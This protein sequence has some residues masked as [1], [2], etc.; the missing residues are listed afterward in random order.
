MAYFSAEYKITL[1]FPDR[2]LINISGQD[3]TN[4]VPAEVLEILPNQAFKGKLSDEATAN[5]ILA[6][7][8]PPNIN[9]QA[10]VGP[11]LKELGFLDTAAPLGAFGISISKDMVI[12]PG[13][14][15]FALIRVQTE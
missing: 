8:Q 10:I 5:M 3:K 15:Y 14:T 1:R 6:A 4:Y 2:P 9:A 13:N 12:V 7:C 11:G